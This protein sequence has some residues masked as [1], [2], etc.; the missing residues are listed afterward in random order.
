MTPVS[1]PS[2]ERTCVTVSSTTSIPR[3]RKPARAVSSTSAGSVTNAVT[4]SLNARNISAW[5]TPFGVVTST[6]MRWSRISHPWQNGQ[7]TT[8]RPH[9]SAR[10][11]TCGRTSTAP[12]AT[13]SLRAVTTAP[14]SSVTEKPTGS[15][16]SPVVADAATILP[17]VTSTP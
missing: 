13:T 15:V 12:E 10:P 6:P 4:C 1:V 8:P 17:A 16:P 7:C 14:E 5:C 3:A 9:C 11:G 2:D